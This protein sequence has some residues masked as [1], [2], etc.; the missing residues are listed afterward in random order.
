MNLAR[1][2]R[3]GLHRLGLALAVVPPL[4]FIGAVVGQE[5]DHWRQLDSQRFVTEKEPQGDSPTLVIEEERQTGPWWAK[6]PLAECNRDQWLEAEKRKILPADKAEALVHFR[7]QFP[8]GLPCA[9]PTREPGPWTKYSIADIMRVKENINAMISEHAT[10]QAIEAYVAA[11]GLT[12]KQLRQA[13]K[14]GSKP[15]MFDDLIPVSTPQPPPEF[16]RL[17]YF[18]WVALAALASFILYA[19]CWVL[20]WIVAGFLG[21]TKSS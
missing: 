12:A 13:P 21:E 2:I 9:L 6:S 16:D 4:V 11:E 19:S 14:L 17:Q 1:N 10:E 15:G 8:L 5:R 3:T 7:K 20:G 18:G